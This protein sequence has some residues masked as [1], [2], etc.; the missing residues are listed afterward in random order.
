MVIAQN[1][2]R[3]ERT[4]TPLD[5]PTILVWLDFSSTRGQLENIWLEDFLTRSTPS[6]HISNNLLTMEQF[7]FYTI[8]SFLAYSTKAVAHIC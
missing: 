3:L 1:S 8:F 6:A 2:T 7:P 5:S 4:I